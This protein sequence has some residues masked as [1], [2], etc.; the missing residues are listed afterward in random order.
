MEVN[1]HNRLKYFPI[2]LFAS[3]MGL[4]GLCIVLLKMAPVL[5]FSNYFGVT[6][7]YLVSAWFVLL[8]I[9]YGLKW[10]R[11]PEEVKVEFNHPV[12]MHFFP[13]YSICFLLFAIAFL[14]VNPAVSMVTWWI[15]AVL[16][17]LLLL[18]T[19]YAWFHKNYKLQ[20]FNP[21]WFIP[22]VGPILVP[23]AGTQVANPEISWFFFSVGVI[24]WIGLLSIFLYR[25]IFHE[26]LPTKLVPTLFILIAPA[27]VGFIAYIKLTHSLDP[28]SRILFYF[29]IFTVLM[30]LTMIDKFAKVPFFISW[31]AYT[32][33]LD[34]VTLSTVLMY[35]LT[36]FV[37]FKVLAGIFMGFTV[38]IILFVLIKTVQ[39]VSRG[40]LCVPEG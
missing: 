35:E 21:A 39:A 19:L 13:A 24:Y 36:H 40:Q 34:A 6:L 29:G 1:T 37:F 20:S 17:L 5:H 8:N 3:V 25:V 33:P 14:T 30:L 12:R 23:V 10:I 32:F 2:T 11:Y 16:H 7:L 15:G 38:L 4:A 31:W 9:I 27:A 28:F 22:V 18:R 26:P